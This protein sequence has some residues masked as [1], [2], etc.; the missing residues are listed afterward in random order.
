MA[1][2]KKALSNECSAPTKQSSDARAWKVWAML[3]E[4]FGNAFPQK[5]GANPGPLW[6]EVIAELTDAQVK[7]G[8][9]SI[10]KAGSPFPP[11]MPEFKAACLDESGADDA[12][13]IERLAYELIS[14]FDRSNKTAKDL[15]F[16]QKNNMDRA[17]ALLS[18]DADPKGSEVNTM[19][20]LGY[21]AGQSMTVQ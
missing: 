10:M 13:K 17:R 6:R 9:D 12:G 14:S 5:F 15:A 21:I 4:M 11:S 2:S 16:M 8:L 3:T 19:A 20:R 7:T 18:R 1:D